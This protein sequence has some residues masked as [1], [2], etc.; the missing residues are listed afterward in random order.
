MFM[1][2]VDMALLGILK[3]AAEQAAQFQRKGFRKGLRFKVP[4]TFG[5]CFG[6]LTIIHTFSDLL[7]RLMGFRDICSCS[8]DLLQR[9]DIQQDQQEKKMEQV[10]CGRG[11][12][13]VSKVLPQGTRVGCHRTSFFLQQLNTCVV[14]LPREA[15]LRLGF[16][17]Y[18]GLTLLKFL[19]P[20]KKAGVHHKSHLQKQLRQPGWYGRIQY[21]RH[22]KQPYH[23]G[24]YRIFL[25]VKFPGATARANNASRSSQRQQHQAYCVNSLL[26]ITRGVNGLLAFRVPEG[27]LFYF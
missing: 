14:F 27:T 16:I 20:R 23:L 25:Q 17:F 15:C 1:T 9:W 12:M 6:H 19:T 8:Y 26:Q 7:E 24:A 13:Q 11:Q 3:E 18:W 2:T 10:E 5:N 21:S 4:L 22:T